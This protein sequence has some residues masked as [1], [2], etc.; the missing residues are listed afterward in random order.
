VNRNL[1]ELTKNRKPAEEVLA[2]LMSDSQT[3]SL[4]AGLALARNAADYGLSVRDYLQLA[5]DPSKGEY[6]NDQLDGY[7]TALMAANLPV[8]N[9]FAKGVVLQAASETFQ[10]FP[11]MRILFP[12]VMD[13]IVQWQYRQDQLEKVDGMISQSRT[14]SGTELITTVVTDGAEQYQQFGRIAERGTIPVRTIQGTEHSVKFYK[15][16]GGYELTYEFSRRASLDIL[17]PYAA[18]QE[19]EVA[20]AQTATVTELL[21][22]GD[23]VHAAASVT[24]AKD[25]SATIGDASY[26]QGKINWEAL[27]KWLVLR[28]QAGTPIDTIVGNY[29]M[30][31]EWL[32][33]FAKPSIGLGT[34]QAE[35][36]RQAGVN[37]AEAN[38]RFKF[39]VNFEVSSTAPAQKL[40]G[41]SKADTVEELVES[42][43]DIQESIQ[44][45]QNQTVKYVRT[46][47]RG[48]RLIF[49]DTRDVLD[50]SNA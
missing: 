25:L 21:Y 38:P 22:N 6:A 20:I 5:I 50:L 1:I 41:F 15:Y 48:Y 43:S 49:G 17:T 19:R 18:R 39:N 24:N 40:M 12:P 3:E 13:D 23:P 4:E 34:P 11:G 47:N 2:K 28:A 30:H 36:L 46:T 42:G 27:L 29:D 33:M 16:G 44:A 32:R 45:A 8:R 35:V 37:M 14:I 7:K 26:A 31:F 9:D 10:T